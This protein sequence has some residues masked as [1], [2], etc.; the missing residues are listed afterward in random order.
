MPESKKAKSVAPKSGQSVN[1]KLM[2]DNHH[3]AKIIA[4]LNQEI[5]NLKTK[6]TDKSKRSV[7]LI[8]GA[9]A[10][11]QK[12]HKQHPVTMNKALRQLDKLQANLLHYKVVQKHIADLMHELDGS[13]VNKTVRATVVNKHQPT[14]S[15]VMQQLKNTHVRAKKPAVI[16][17]AA[18]SGKQPPPLP[19]EYRRQLLTSPA[20]P[21]SSIPPALQ[22][23]MEARK[24]PEYQAWLSKKDD[25]SKFTQAAI[26]GIYESKDGFKNLS[27]AITFYII[28]FESATTLFQRAI[29]IHSF[30]TIKDK[31]FAELQQDTVKIILS[32]L[33]ISGDEL[34][35][36]TLHQ[37][38]PRKVDTFLHSLD[39]MAGSNNPY[40]FKDKVLQQ[41]KKLDPTPENLL[42]NKRKI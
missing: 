26:A 10:T 12:A 34:F 22:A 1:S 31:K 39:K 35:F 30:L 5:K 41:L 27:D 25:F 17:D 3:L 40:Q 33:N 20:K 15:K 9:I 7:Q 16:H 11:L 13:T 36:G 4:S 32:E 29:I 37:L 14:H 23:E 19:Q 42:P 2:L 24:S 21:A 18:K 6:R 38:N 8:N 28:L